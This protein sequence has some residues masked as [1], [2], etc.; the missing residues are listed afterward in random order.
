MTKATHSPRSVDNHHLHTTLDPNQIT[1]TVPLQAVELT[2]VL[3]KSTQT[4]LKIQNLT[5]NFTQI[6]AEKNMEDLSPNLSQDSH[7]VELLEETIAME[8]PKIEAL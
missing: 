8:E 3:T 2:T 4:P 6:T 5:E 1:A 7:P